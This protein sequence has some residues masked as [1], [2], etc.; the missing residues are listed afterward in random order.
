MRKWF[1]FITLMVVCLFPVGAQAQTS[2]SFNAVAVDIW[3]EYDQPSVLVIDH[4]TLGAD[5]T[6]PA[7]L[8]LRVPIQASVNAVAVSDDSGALITAD[9]QRKV[10]GDWAI[11]SVESTSQ[12]IQVEYYDQYIQQGDIRQ[13][14]FVWPGNYPVD[15]FSVNFQQPVGATNLKLTPALGTGVVAADGLTYYN[16]TIGALPANQTFTLNIEYQKTTDTLSTSGQ[17]VQ[18]SAP[19]DANVQG[20]V[21]FS[22]YLPWILGGLGGL[23]VVGGLV[24]GLIYWKREQKRSSNDSRKRHATIYKD[25]L[26]DAYCNQCG[27]RSQPG[28]VFCRTCGS[29]LRRTD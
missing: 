6:L 5:V 4:Y 11:L 28:D 9:Y 8:E 22:E 24:V 14:D 17:S 23:L 3:P 19:L 25:A 2:I 16:K 10:S 12:N 21:S 18:P 20:R 26:G 29:R 7:N 15:A 1:L 27:K 13:Y